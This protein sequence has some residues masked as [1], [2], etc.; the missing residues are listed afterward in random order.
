[1]TVEKPQQDLSQYCFDPIRFVRSGQLVEGVLPTSAFAE[2]AQLL[3]EDVVLSIKGAL[4]EAGQYV[5]QGTLQTSVT[6]SC[7]RCQH[8]LVYPLGLTWS[9]VPVL[10]DE[11]AKCLPKAYDPLV[12]QGERVTLSSIVEEEM[13]LSLPM[14]A[15]HGVGAC[16]I[17]LPEGLEVA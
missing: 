16:P 12:T 3:N 17:P 8:P 13:L 4:D 2:L 10:T 9:L 14:I 5:L 11:Q 7:E 1:M 6:L 15:R